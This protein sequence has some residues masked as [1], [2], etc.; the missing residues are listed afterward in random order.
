[1]WFK[2][3]SQISGYNS[4][5]AVDGSDWRAT[6]QFGNSWS[7]SNILPSVA[8][9]SN[10]FYLPALGLYR[11][12]QLQWVGNSGYYWSSSAN[13]SHSSYAYTLYFNSSSIG[14]GVYDRSDGF[15]VDGFE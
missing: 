8:N 9:A 11:V 1:M 13:T 3:K 10:Y 7:V 4:S 2:K 14:V 5:T 6:Y 15:R 12:G